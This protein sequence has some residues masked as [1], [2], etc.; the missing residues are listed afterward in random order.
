MDPN[1]G[2]FSWFGPVNPGI[3]WGNHF[4]GSVPVYSEGRQN[5]IGRWSSVIGM[6]TVSGQLVETIQGNDFFKSA[7]MAVYF[8]ET[9]AFGPVIIGQRCQPDLYRILAPSVQPLDIRAHPLTWQRSS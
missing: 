5:I 8:P 2:N 4:V 1:H 3:G 6:S 7:S 9:Y